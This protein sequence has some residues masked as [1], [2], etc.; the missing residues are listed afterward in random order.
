MH[1]GSTS[2]DVPDAD[3]CTNIRVPKHVTN[4]HLAIHLKL[5]LGLVEQAANWR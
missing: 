5:D 1:T 3:D 4:L 2:A